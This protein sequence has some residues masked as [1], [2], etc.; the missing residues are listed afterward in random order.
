MSAVRA[1]REDVLNVCAKLSDAQWQVPSMAEGW[2][3]RDVVAHL[4]DVSRLLV[5]PAAVSAMFGS[6]AEGTN[7]ELVARHASQP[8]DR[9]VAEYEKW[10]ARAAGVLAVGARPPVGALPIRVSNLGWYPMR[11]VPS[12]LA[13]DTYVHLRH[14]IAPA[15]NMELPPVSGERLAVV[16]EWMMAGLEQMNR[17]SMGWLDQPIAINLDG[18]GGGTWH[19]EPRRRGRLSVRPGPA[20]RTSAEIAGDA[21]AFPSWATT[22]SAWRDADLVLSGDRELATKFLDSLDIV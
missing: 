15:L 14:D 18:P 4:G 7:D 17:D 6:D 12:M 1:E 3:V 22:R 13:F 21:T 11:L 16:L 5:T 8:L 19:V 10:S 9:I 2:L 20:G